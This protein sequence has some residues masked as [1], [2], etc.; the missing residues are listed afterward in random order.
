MTKIKVDNP[1]VEMD[2]D[3]MTRIIWDFIKKKLIL[4]YLDIDLLYYDLGIEERDRTNDQITID[5]AMK[6]KEVGV[7]VKCA[8]IT[9]DEARVEEFGLKQMWRSP[10]GTIR[11]ILGGVIFREPIICKNVPRL[12]PG[13]TQPIVVGRHAFGDQYRATDFLFPGKGK[14]TMKFVGEDGTVI[15]RDVFDAPAAGVAMGMYNL[16][17]SIIDFARSSMNYGLL[18]GWPVYLSTK[19]TILKAY[20]GRF[21]D[22]F[23][24]VYEEEFEA[25]FKKAGIHYEH[26]LI[27]DMVASALKWSGG[28]IWACKNYDGDVQSDTVAQGFGSLGLMTSVL[29]TPDGKTVEA[30]AAHGTVTRHYR[31]HQAGKETSTN[32]IAS[33]FAWTGGL[34]HRAKLDG[35]EALANFAA[36]LEK[37][38]VQTVED[39]FMTK[40]LALLVGPDQK[41]L[42][43]MGYLEKVDE[44]L[45]KALAG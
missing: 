26:R 28:Y 43:T 27:D 3:E 21:K 40:D 42:T 13:W 1:I 32:S 15:E 39:G 4:P 7:A 10:N 23:Q 45:N 22:L 14:L 35:N 33:I 18:K 34:K 6:T 44:Y 5:S 19:N 2:G 11:N 20:D 38:C 31:Q 36:T 41:W 37:V 30:E 25:E 17:Q 29:M 16:D 12:V 8:T 9:P 24:K